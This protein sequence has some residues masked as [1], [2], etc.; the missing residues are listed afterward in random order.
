MSDITQ[1]EKKNGHSQLFLLS[2]E[3][4]IQCQVK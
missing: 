3:I 4:I 2:K 1:V